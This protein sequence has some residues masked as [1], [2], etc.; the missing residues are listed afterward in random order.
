MQEKGHF[1][2]VCSSRR[3][4]NHVEE[5]ELQSNLETEIDH[6][7]LDQEDDSEPEYGV[8]SITPR[9]IRHTVQ[10]CSLKLLK[11]N[12]ST[13]RNLSV[14]LRSYG[15]SFY[16]AVDTGS[17]VSFLNKRTADV[18]LRQNPKSRFISAHNMNDEISYVDYNKNS[19]KIFGSLTIPVS[20]GG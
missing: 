18:L 16:A 8:L 11:S 19:I 6:I 17:P 9:R 14:M 12:R 7:V 5:E 20:S 2:K 15:K 13:P 4:V 1:A 10:N 3:R